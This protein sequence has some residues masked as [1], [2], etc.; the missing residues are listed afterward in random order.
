VK[1]LEDFAHQAAVADLPEREVK[2]VMFT[3]QRRVMAA[4]REVAKQTGQTVVRA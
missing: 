3:G 2:E 4:A 1:R